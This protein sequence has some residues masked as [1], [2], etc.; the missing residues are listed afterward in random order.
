MRSGK[1]KGVS[2]GEGLKTAKSGVNSG[3]S[4]IA[5][6][7]KDGM[8]NQRKEKQSVSPQVPLIDKSDLQ[9]S[10]EDYLHS[11]FKAPLGN[12]PQRFL[13]FDVGKEIEDS[14]RD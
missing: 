9:L 11:T 12:L 3:K 13:K 10:V 14:H 4:K 2:D 6:I 5:S 1:S 8:R 7:E